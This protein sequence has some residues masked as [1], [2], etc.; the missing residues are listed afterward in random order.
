MVV[1]Q[2]LGPICANRIRPNL[3]KSGHFDLLN[4][5]LS[6]KIGTFLGDIRDIFRRVL[7][8]NGLVEKWVQLMSFYIYSFLN[9]R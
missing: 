7:D 9:S 5:Y 8:G 6:G 4:V 1:A 3:I 2:N